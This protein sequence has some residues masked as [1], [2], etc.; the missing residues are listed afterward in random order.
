MVYI[1]CSFVPWN[2]MASTCTKEQNKL[3][4]MKSCFHFPRTLSMRRVTMFFSRWVGTRNFF[5]KS[6]L[7]ILLVILD[8]ELFTSKIM[9]KNFTS[10]F[11]FCL[12]TKNPKI[13]TNSQKTSKNRDNYLKV[14]TNQ[15]QIGTQ[16]IWRK[17][18]TVPAN[19]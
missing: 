19:I 6:V 3:N 13:G 15:V 9:K 1:I 5:L 7:W 17:N 16:D 2:N 12:S 8:F 4:I 11:F 14:G 10:I 18:G